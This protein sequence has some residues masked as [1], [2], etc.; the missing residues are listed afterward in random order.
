MD[1]IFFPRHFLVLGFSTNEIKDCFWR[2]KPRLFHCLCFLN[3]ASFSFHI[4][5][6]S[7]NMYAKIVVLSKFHLSPIQLEEMICS[8][9]IKKH[10]IFMLL[11]VSGHDVFFFSYLSPCPK[12]SHAVKVICCYLHLSPLSIVRVI[13]LSSISTCPTKIGLYIVLNL[14]KNINRVALGLYMLLHFVKSS[15]FKRLKSF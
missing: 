5:Y 10:N 3:C 9:R 8:P 12:D 13:T 4:F 14:V 15:L 1:L 6:F 11:L 2:G 7:S